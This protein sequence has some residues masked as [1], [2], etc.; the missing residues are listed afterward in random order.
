MLC[1]LTEQE[2]DLLQRLRERIFGRHLDPS[3]FC[4]LVVVQLVAA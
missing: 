4:A 1:C 3:I 2:T